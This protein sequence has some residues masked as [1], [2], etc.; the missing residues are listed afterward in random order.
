MEN[1]GTVTG[2]TSREVLEETREESEAKRPDWM[3]RAYDEALQYA[4]RRLAEESASQFPEQSG[5][6]TGH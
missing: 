2:Q 4:R 6:L 1:Q 3:R 5:T